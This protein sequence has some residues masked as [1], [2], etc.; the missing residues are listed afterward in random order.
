MIKTENEDYDHDGGVT[1]NDLGG[2]QGQL[3]PR[4]LLIAFDKSRNLSD[5][6]ELLLP[7]EEKT[8]IFLRLLLDFKSTV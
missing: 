1:L 7:F 2:I 3:L 4:F 6:T 5:N 8:L